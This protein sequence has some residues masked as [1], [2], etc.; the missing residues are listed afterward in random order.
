MY[1]LFK[2]V[3]VTLN[4]RVKLKVNLK[5]DNLKILKTLL[6]SPGSANLTVQEAKHPDTKEE[7][8]S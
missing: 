3:K 2:A 1:E 7:V 4:S 6:S 5:V 8:P